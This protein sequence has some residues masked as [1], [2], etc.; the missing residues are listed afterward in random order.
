MKTERLMNL[1]VAKTLVVHDTERQL[2]QPCLRIVLFGTALDTVAGLRAPLDAFTS[3]FGNG[4][5]WYRNDF[6]Q[7]NPKRWPKEGGEALLDA[8][9]REMALAKGSVAELLALSKKTEWVVP[10]FLY[11]KRGGVSAPFVA[12]SLPL[13]Y[14]EKVGSEG[15]D[16]FLHE[17]LAA[18]FPL[19]SGYVGLSLFWNHSVPSDGV[20]LAGF[21]RNC[22]ISYP[23]LMHPDFRAQI[24]AARSGLVDVGWYTLLGPELAAK[25]G[26]FEQVSSRIP[27]TLRDMIAFDT[28]PNGAMAI[29]AGSTPVLG[30]MKSGE[31]A[32]LQSA[33]GSALSGLC[34]AENNGKQVVS[35]FAVDGEIDER[36]RWANRFFAAM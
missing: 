17:V 16:S 13:E 4:V 12:I 35:G 7:A 36:R 20:R 32:Q 1:D 31:V 10:A 8:M 34:D 24:Q 25:A 2:C 14:L 15:V 27:A 33:V 11:S 9:R 3:R 19:A 30:D 6:H 22:L 5:G 26:S 23:G 21:F 18:D 29:K 28:F